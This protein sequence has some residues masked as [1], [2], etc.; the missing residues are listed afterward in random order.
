MGEGG[1]SFI[2]L[3]GW[4]HHAARLTLIAR[5]R[6]VYMKS[7]D[8]EMLAFSAHFQKALCKRQTKLICVA[9]S[10]PGSLE[11]RTTCSVAIYIPI[12]LII[13]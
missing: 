7:P 9:V 1:R 2:V 3:Q 10:C 12:V 5:N 11:Q 8:F 4:E 13:D 6:D